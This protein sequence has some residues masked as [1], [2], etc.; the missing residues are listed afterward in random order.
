MLLNNFP[1]FAVCGSNWL[2]L[3]RMSL[4]E[5]ATTL[6]DT[7][8][9]AVG[10]GARGDTMTSV[11]LANEALWG[12]LSGGVGRDKLGLNLCNELGRSLLHNFN[13]IFT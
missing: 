5:C 4:R 11:W 2:H 9:R 3:L 7:A 6:W 12:W 1:L 10:K 13:L 8:L